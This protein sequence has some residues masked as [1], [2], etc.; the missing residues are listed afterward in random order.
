MNRLMIAGTRSGVGKTTVAMGLMASLSK[1][2]VVQPYKVG[3]DYID[4]AFHTFITGRDSRNLD[5]YM[6]SDTM[7]KYLFTKNMLDADIGILEGVMGLFD[8]A[9]IGSEIGTSASIGKKLQVPVIL[10]VDG[11]KVGGSIAATV[12]GFNNFDSELKIAG[13]IFNRVGSQHHYELLKEAVEVATDV[14]PCGYLLKSS[15]ITLPERHLGLVPAGE[16]NRL[17]S[18]FD[19]LAEQIEKTVDI[20][21]LLEIAQTE[22]KLEL[23]EPFEKRNTEPLRIGIA[24]DAA[25]NF[26]YQDA[27]DLLEK[28]EAVTWVPFSPLKDSCLPED[29]QGIYLGGGFPE[30]FSKELALNKAFKTD[31]LEKL[32]SGMPYIAECGGLMYLCEALIDLEGQS[33]AMLGWLKGTTQMKQRLQR[34]GYSQVTTTGPTVFGEE[35]QCIKVHEFHHSEA[36]IDEATSYKVEKIKKGQVVKKWRCGYQKKNGVAAY[37]HMHFA[38]NMDFARGFVDTCVLWKKK[39]ERGD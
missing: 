6:M 1:R 9:E 3:P 18:I 12:Q 16:L 34:F 15:T 29:L 17:S 24:K 10:V 32:E 20:E 26:Y 11:S 36:K 14:V 8:G 19:Q 4:P 39:I 30:V 28:Y 37:A 35:G 23:M 2:M 13:V 22:S 21:A 33:H 5:S 31:L 7:T 27:L 38:S 25:F